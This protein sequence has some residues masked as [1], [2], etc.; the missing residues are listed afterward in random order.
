MIEIGYYMTIIT[1]HKQGKSQREIAKLVGHDRK[2]VGR[3]I[4][5]Y[6]KDGTTEFIRNNKAPILE[7]HK[8]LVIELMEKEFRN[9]LSKRCSVCREHKG[10][11]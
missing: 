10:E 11:K 8:D 2:T 3:I 7:G 9:K 4:K 6:K 1:L 5:Q